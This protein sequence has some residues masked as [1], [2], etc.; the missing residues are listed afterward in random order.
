MLGPGLV[1]LGELEPVPEYEGAP[2]GLRWEPD[3]TGRR[4]PLGV[5]IGFVT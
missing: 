4:Q 1:T 2:N 3:R 5:M